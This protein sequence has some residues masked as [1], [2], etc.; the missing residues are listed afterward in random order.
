MNSSRQVTLDVLDV[1]VHIQSYR[2]MKKNLDS[3]FKTMNESSH[4]FRYKC[5]CTK[6]VQRESS[7]ILDDP[8]AKHEYRHRG[9]ETECCE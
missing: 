6:Q 3:E 8:I 7:S 5:I 1:A 9:R 2:G 4:Q